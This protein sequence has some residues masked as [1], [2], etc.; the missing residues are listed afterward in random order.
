MIIVGGGLVG[1][2]LALALRDLPLSIALIDAKLPSKNDPR[3]FGLN[4]SSCRMLN[5]LAIW[6]LV[7]KHASPIN[8]VHVTHRGVFGGVRLKAEEAELKNLG[9]VLPA[10]HLE[11]ALHEAM[12]GLSNVTVLRPANVMALSQHG[13]NTT[14]TYTQGDQTNTIT[15]PLIIGADGTESSLRMLCNI[16]TDV[17]D[18][19]QTA[20]V[21]RV[22]LSRP[23]QHIAYERF[24]ESGAI[25]MLPLLGDEY[26]CIWTAD[27]KRAEMLLAMSD[28]AYLSALQLEFGYRLGRLVGIKTRYQFPLKMKRARQSVSGNVFLLG[29]ALHT[30]H[31]IA[32]QGFNLALFEV[33]ALVEGITQALAQSAP[34]NSQLLEKISQTTQNQQKTSIDVSDGLAQLFKTGKSLVNNVIGLG[35]TGFDCVPPLKKYF[36]D[37]MTGRAGFTPALLR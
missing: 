8:A 34:I 35:M 10:C 31:P 2:S 26:A 36:I 18:Y 24:C 1:A 32:A 23:H 11:A 30:L 16:P 6:P 37:Q 7:S 12:E 29:N 19:A 28:Q 22:R 25:A 27:N 9:H 4:V 13:E 17:K 5:H 14:L 21:T 3:L 33:A 20:I 15:A